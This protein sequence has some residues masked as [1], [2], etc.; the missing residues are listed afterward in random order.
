MSIEVKV[1]GNILSTPESRFVD[2]KGER[3]RITELRI[4]SNGYKRDGEGNFISDD[5]KSIPFTVTVW[6]ERLAE[7]VLEH[8]KTGAR[9]S[10]EGSLSVDQWTDKEDG[11]DRFSL[12]IDA[13]AVTLNLSRVEKITWIPKQSRTS[14]DKQ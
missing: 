8:L 6:K 10:V 9:I 4:M 12:K 7:A 14:Q 1:S 5:E 11:K 3:K 13:S 2:V